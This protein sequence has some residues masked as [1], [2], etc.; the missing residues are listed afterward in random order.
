MRG[1]SVSVASEAS[2]SATYAR[3]WSALASQ[4]L[5]DQTSADVRAERASHGVK[6]TEAQ[7]EAM[8]RELVRQLIDNA[9]PCR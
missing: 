6:K 1:L 5:A 3:S 4:P 2:A 9:D 7:R 8:S